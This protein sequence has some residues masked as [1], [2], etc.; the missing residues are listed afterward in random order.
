MIDLNEI[1]RDTISIFAGCHSLIVSDKK[2]M[3]DPLEKIFFEKTNW[4]YSFNG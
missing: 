3:G 4:K 1:S 2:L